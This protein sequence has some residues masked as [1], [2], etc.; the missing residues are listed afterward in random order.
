MNIHDLFKL[1]GQLIAASPAVNYSTIHTRDLEMLRNS[2]LVKSNGDYLAK[3]ELN[4]ECKFELK[5]WLAVLPHCYNPL[6]F[7][8]YLVVLTTDSS[9]TGWGAHTDLEVTRGFWSREE[10]LLHINTLELI[11]VLN[12]LKSLC[13]NLTGCSILIRSDNTTTIA[14]INKFGG[15]RSAINLKSAKAVWEWCEERS[16]WIFA[17][18]I[19]SVD[20]I[21]ADRQ[22]RQAIDESDFT[23]DS[24]SFDLICQTFGVSFIDLFATSMSTKCQRFAS[25][26]PD[27]NCEVVDSFTID[28]SEFFY[29][30]P[31]FSQISKVLRK[32]RNDNATGIVVVPDWST[33]S[34]Y[35]QFSRL[36]LS[37]ILEGESSSSCFI[38]QSNQ[39]PENVTKLL[40][41]SCQDSTWKQY[42]SNFKKWKAYCVENEC[43]VWN[44]TINSILS[45]LATLFDSGLG[46]TTINSMR[47]SLST[48]IGKV[49]GQSLGSHPLLIV[50]D[51]LRHPRLMTEALDRW[52]LGHIK[53]QLPLTDN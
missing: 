33:Q 24:R 50:F 19:K 34:W 53:R 13:S 10:Q 49:D 27:P 16:I 39:F 23:L 12:G 29:A 30:F 46:Y 32:I 48:I 9:T 47:S 14:Y 42:Q 2:A 5:W 35:P 44:P 1:T 17:S 18:Y 22:S 37:N 7:Q 36:L 26:Y 40:K 6:R 45:F 3:C 43:S 21:I 41:S 51:I 25:W 20:N 31:P 38:W 28:W 52:R 8:K 4:E 11:A 15:C